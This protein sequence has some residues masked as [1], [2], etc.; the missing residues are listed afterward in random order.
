MAMIVFHDQSFA[1]SPAFLFMLEEFVK[2][3]KTGYADN[4]LNFT[5]SSFVDYALDDQQQVAGG[6]IWTYDPLKRSAWILF[7]AVR[8]NMRKKG[9]YKSIIVNVE[10]IA[11]Q[12]GAIVIYSSVHVDNEA[13]IAAAKS[14]GRQPN[15]Y[16]AKKE[17][18]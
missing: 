7:S 1:H 9:V 16:R 12:K 2:L 18:K 11:K 6:C 4:E 17:F 13:M 8:E 5:N 14:S 3:V 10:R 15:W